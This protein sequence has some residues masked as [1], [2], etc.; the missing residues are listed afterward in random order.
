MDLYLK[1]FVTEI[2]CIFLFKIQ[3][4]DNH[5]RYRTKRK[6]CG[7][8][9]SVALLFD[10]LKIIIWLCRKR[11]SMN[12]FDGRKSVESG[13]A[14]PRLSP[15]WARASVVSSAGPRPR[16][17]A[18]IST[19]SK[20]T[21]HYTRIED[22]PRPATCREVEVGSGQNRGSHPIPRLQGHPIVD[23]KLWH[24]GRH[25]GVFPDDW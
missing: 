16:H 5:S 23:I 3:K 11:K 1:R 6:N 21:H 18:N 15:S 20:W 7:C 14:C 10:Q 13:S 8:N 9:F 12:E 19:I 4:L 24:K 2:I 17:P 25:P 22:N